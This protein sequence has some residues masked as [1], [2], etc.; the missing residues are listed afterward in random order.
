M[1]KIQ[2]T[3]EQV[4]LLMT[5]LVELTSRFSMMENMQDEVE[6]LRK[7]RRDIRTQMNF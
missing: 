2:L 5:S 3:D 6:D 7:L 1:H 4:E